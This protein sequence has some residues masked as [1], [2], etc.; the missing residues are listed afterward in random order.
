MTAASRRLLTRP[1]PGVGSRE[2]RKEISSARSLQQAPVC[3]SGA[4]DALHG[5][6]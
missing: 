3:A 1:G 4:P 6:F 2:M 5:G